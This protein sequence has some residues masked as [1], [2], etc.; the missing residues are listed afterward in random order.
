MRTMVVTALVLL[1]ISRTAASLTAADET[2]PRDGQRRLQSED[3][4]RVSAERHSRQ[5]HTPGPSRRSQRPPASHRH[6]PQL[7]RAP[8]DP[9]APEL[10]GVNT[11]SSQWY[12]VHRATPSPAQNSGHSSG[13][14]HVSRHSVQREPSGLQHSRSSHAAMHP[15]LPEGAALRRIRIQACSVSHGSASEQKTAQ[16]CCQL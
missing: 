12:K 13:H 8:P 9:R 7:H 4:T 16:V 14:E 2:L 11:H 15:P 5:H 6:P 3:V 1:S 10:T